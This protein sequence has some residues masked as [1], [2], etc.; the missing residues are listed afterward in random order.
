MKYT[1][2]LFL[3][4]LFFSCDQSSEQIELQPDSNSFFV[5]TNQ[6]IIKLQTFILKKAYLPALNQTK[7][8]NSNVSTYINEIDVLDNKSWSSLETELQKL[9]KKLLKKEDDFLLQQSLQKIKFHLIN[10]SLKYHN[11]QYF[12]RLWSFENAL[13]QTTKVAQDPLLDLYEW[14]EFQEMVTC[15]N[16]EW[17]PLRSL[18]LKQSY[19]D[20]NEELVYSYYHQKTQLIQ[21]LDSFNVAVNSDDHEKY[22][23]CEYGATLEWK[24]IQ[25]LQTLNPNDT[26][27]AQNVLL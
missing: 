27:E 18:K 15:M 6:D 26:G 10:I 16:Q 23:L 7:K 19:I 13:L 17:I 1:V 22:D 20:Y 12:P 2:L 14:G 5:S 11:D 25:F 4:L 21:A 8:T 9:E 24:Y 3:S